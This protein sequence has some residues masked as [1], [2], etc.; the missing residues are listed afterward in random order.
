MNE[1]VL[2]L[3]ELIQTSH[4]VAK[5][6][7]DLFARHGLTPTQFGVL[8]CLEDGDDF[9]KAQL[10]RAVLVTP[11]SMDPLITS[12]LTRGLVD[13]NGPAGRGRAA[14]IHITKAGRALMGQVRPEVAHFNASEHIGVAD[15]DIP[16]LMTNLRAIRHFLD[17]TSLDRDPHG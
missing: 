3:W 16:Q 5:G 12:L 4:I 6:F 8:A 13:R 1:P 7:R 14:G 17:K 15:A 2:P 11:Q 9:T 10:A